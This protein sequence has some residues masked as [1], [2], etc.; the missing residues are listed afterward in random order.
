MYDDAD[1][2]EFTNVHELFNYYNNLCFKNALGPVLVAWSRKLKR[3]AGI[4]YYKVSQPPGICIIRLSEPLLKYRCIDDYK[5]TLLH[6]MIH[7]YLFL[8]QTRHKRTGHGKQF[9][10]WMNKVNQLTGLKVSIRHNFVE[11][12]K[13]Y[14]KY[15]W[16][17]NGICRL[18]PP[19]FGYIRRAI[20]LAPSAKDSWWSD[21][22]ILCGGQFV[23]IHI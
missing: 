1:D 8:T 19:S 13:Y 4:C 12:V 2:L 22:L 3:C 23:Q 6:E 17:C 9:I 20:N 16:R 11:E 14:R 18:N 10:K 15:V 21:H 5:Q 7:A